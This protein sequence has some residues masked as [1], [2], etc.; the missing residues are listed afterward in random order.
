MDVTSPGGPDRLESDHLAG[1][2]GLMP[3]AGGQQ[4]AVIQGAYYLIGSEEDQLMLLAGA[5][6]S[7][8]QDGDAIEEHASQLQEDIADLARVPDPIILTGDPTEVIGHDYMMGSRRI[9]V[10]DAQDM[11]QDLTPGAVV[12]EPVLVVPYRGDVIPRGADADLPTPRPEARSPPL[13][14][15]L[16]RFDANAGGIL[17][18]VFRHVRCQVDGKERDPNRQGAL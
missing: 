8:R 11:D 2:G 1:L 4:E 15:G 14:E 13:P 18:A 10:P 9:A 5:L 17:Q 7:E 16:R 12:R 6:G 3:S